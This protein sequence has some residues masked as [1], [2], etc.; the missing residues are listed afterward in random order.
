MEIYLKHL[1]VIG[2]KKKNRKKKEKKKKKRKCKYCKKENVNI[3]FFL[4][5]K[6]AWVISNT[7]FK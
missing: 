7:P 1:F 4:Y 6:S 3:V 2:R 5:F